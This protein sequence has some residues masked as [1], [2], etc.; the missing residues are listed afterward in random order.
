[1]GVGD[2]MTHASVLGSTFDGRIVAVTRL[3]DRVA[4]VP[5][6]R[7]SAWITGVTRVLENRAQLTEIAKN[8]LGEEV[9][10]T[11]ALA[12]GNIFIRAAEHLY[13][14]GE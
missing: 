12:H 8:E 7:G 13:C 2:A 6:I 9:Y 3:G 1:M 5:A 14:I 10:S 4:I 11:P